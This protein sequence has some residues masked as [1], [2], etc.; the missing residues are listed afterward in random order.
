[1]NKQGYGL[2]RKGHGN[3]VIELTG[4]SHWTVCDLFRFWWTNDFL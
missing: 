3:T 1:M 2:S 4:S